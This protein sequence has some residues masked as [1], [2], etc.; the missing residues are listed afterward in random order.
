[1]EQ[2]IGSSTASAST[3]HNGLYV[4]SFSSSTDPSFY[5]ASTSHEDTNLDDDDWLVRIC[6]PFILFFKKSL[7]ITLAELLNYIN[8][9]NTIG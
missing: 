6:P 7:F 2:Q 5:R 4:E 1:M 8:I 9:F 3:N